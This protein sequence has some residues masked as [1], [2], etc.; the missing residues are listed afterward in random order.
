MLASRLVLL[1]KIM[2]IEEHELQ[3]SSETRLASA[4]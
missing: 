3:Y 1:A 4:R 2:N